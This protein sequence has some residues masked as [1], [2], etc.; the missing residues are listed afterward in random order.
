MDIQVS[1][2]FHIR[3]IPVHGDL[4]LS[5]M[6]GYSDLPFRRMCRDLGSAMSYTEFVNAVDILH[7]PDF[8]KPKLAFYPG[9]RPVAFQL[10]D[11]APERLQ[12]AALRVQEFGPD[13]ID[14]NMGCADKSVSGRGAGAGLLRTPL[15]IAR[16]FRKLTRVLD[17]PVTG[18]IR[19]GWD[20]DCR[21]Y[22]L[23]ARIVEENGGAALAVHGRTKAQGYSGQADWDPIAE[24]CQSLS[25]PVIGNGDVRTL[26]DIEH[27]KAYTGCKAVMIGRAAI[28]NPWIFSRQERLA[29][30]PLEVR[31]VLET[32]LRYSQDFYGEQRGLVLFRKH[33]SR[34][35][36]PYHLP[37]ATRKQLMTATD[38]R[39]FLDILDQFYSLN[40]T[41]SILTIMATS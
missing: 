14:I 9:E 41:K 3:H 13:T 40:S 30:P 32:H 2:T 16:I 25:I 10:F 31:R 37:E 34:Y 28:G 38:A 27:I 33:A 17:V 20:P 36:S 7:R 29:V 5:P 23:V 22:L 26:E 39:A 19:L 4:I 8:V 15:K 24:I 35:M 18:K 12:E 1:P 6:D 21:N 11:S